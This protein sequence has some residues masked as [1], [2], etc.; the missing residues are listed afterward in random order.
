ML[1][2]HNISPNPAKYAQC[3]NIIYRL[4]TKNRIA[5]MPSTQINYLG[6]TGTYVLPIW[7]FF[8]TQIE[9]TGLNCDVEK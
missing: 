1:M 3:L 7:Y 9:K 2:N 5:R 6:T 8:S 4:N